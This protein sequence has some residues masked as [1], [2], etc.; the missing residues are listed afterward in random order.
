MDVPDVRYARSGDVAI[1][2]QAVG[3]A[4]L[5]LIFVRGFAGDL[6]S[7][8]EQPLLVQ[9]HRGPRS[10]RPGDHARQARHRPLR[11][12]AR[13]ADARDPR[14]TT[15]ARSSTTSAPIA[16]GLDGPGGSAARGA[17]RRDVPGARPRPR[18]LRPDREGPAERRLS[19][20]ARPTSSGAGASREIR[21]GWGRTAFLD[22]CLAEWSPRQRDDPEFRAWF[23]AHMRRG[24]SPGSALAFFRMMMDSDVTDVLPVVRV[25]TVVL[26]SESHRGESEYFANRIPGAR[27]VDLPSVRSIYHWVD[28]AAHDVA[29]RETRGLVEA[30]ASERV[31]ERTLTTL[32]FTDL[33]G[34]DG[35]G[36]R[37][38]RPALGGAPR[39]APRAGPEPPRPLSRTRDRHRRRRLPR[40][41]RRAGASG[42][43]RR[44]DPRRS[45]RAR[46][47]GSGRR[48]HRRGRARRRQ[49]RRPDRPRR[50]PHRGAGRAGRDP[51]LRRSSATSSRDRGSSSRT[52]GSTRSRACRTS[53][54]CMPFAASKVLV[55][56]TITLCQSN[57]H[58]DQNWRRGSPA[59]LR[60]VA[61]PRLR[62][63]R[64]HRHPD[65]V[66]RPP[67]R[68]ARAPRSGAVP[69]HVGDPGRL[70]APG[71]RRSTRRPGASFARRPASTAPAC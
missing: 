62:G 15:C 44:G 6:L 70:Q 57:G 65:H 59:R 40:L 33:V 2:Y 22:A 11:P 17:L 23:H 45:A 3:S 64:R 35:Q 28:P 21:D 34:V 66:G 1:A 47:G 54:G 50:C 39:P 25:P 38:R 41:L 31:P 69:G 52:A 58:D 8:W 27:L 42:G 19:V 29:L 4:P 71:R 13:G 49:A 46:P 63:H 5:N 24:L 20:G 36:R 60:P 67:A 14:W 12:R 10:V 37:A 26:S 53:G 32:L 43:V 51:R 7:A 61:V 68:P 9:L 48:A 18:P 16:R 55:D 30:T 56:K